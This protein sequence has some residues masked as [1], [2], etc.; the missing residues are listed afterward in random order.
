MTALNCKPLV[1]AFDTT[2][3]YGSIAL[4]RGGETLE[5]LELHAPGGFAHVLYPLLAELLS[6]HGVGVAAIDCFAAAAGPG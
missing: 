3:E 4:L 6:R 5:E 2:R 1:L